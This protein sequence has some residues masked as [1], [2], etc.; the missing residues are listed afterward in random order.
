MQKNEFK[1]TKKITHLKCEIKDSWI[2][3]NRTSSQCLVKFDW[4]IDWMQ[5][6]DLKEIPS[7]LN[8]IYLCNAP[9]CPWYILYSVRL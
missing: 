6:K 4:F 5:Y 9:M 7:N 8:W 1:K 2:W 3:F